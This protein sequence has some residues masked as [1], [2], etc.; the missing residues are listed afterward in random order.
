MVFLVI[1]LHYYLIVCNNKLNMLSKHIKIGL[2]M[3]F[4]S[5]F[6]ISN[7]LLYFPAALF[8]KNDSKIGISVCTNVHTSN[9]ILHRLLYKKGV[10]I[11]KNGYENRNQRHQIVFVYV[12][13]YA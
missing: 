3:C 5:V 8:A 2:V 4:T 12:D 7:T 6:N 9:A 10:I 1:F 11:D 13:H